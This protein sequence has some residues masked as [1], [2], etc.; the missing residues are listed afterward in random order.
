MSAF[1]P[2]QQ[3]APGWLEVEDDEYLLHLRGFP[4]SAEAECRGLRIEAPVDPN[5][6]HLHLETGGI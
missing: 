4:V 1:V 5:I 2:W 6:S 3:P